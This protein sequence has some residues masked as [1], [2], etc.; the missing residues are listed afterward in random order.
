MFYCRKQVTDTSDVQGE[1]VSQGR[2][3]LGVGLGPGYCEQLGVPCTHCTLP[4]QQPAPPTAKAPVQPAFVQ[5]MG[6]RDGSS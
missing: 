3:S 1:E 5:H 4:P 6:H 2:G